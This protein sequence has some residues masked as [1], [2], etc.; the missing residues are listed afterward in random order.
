ML[1][2]IISPGT[3]ERSPWDMVLLGFLVSSVA[4]WMALLLSE[5][6]NAEPSI[7]ALAITVMALAPLIHRLIVLEEREE[8]SPHRDSLFGF[9]TRHMDVVAVYAFLFV[10]LVLSF[11]FWYAAIPI[12]DYF[13][14]QEVAIDSIQSQVATESTGHAVSAS[15]PQ[16]REQ[17][18][19]FV[20]GNNLRIMLFCFLASFLFGAGALWLI[21]WNASVLGVFI[22]FQIR[23]NIMTGILTPFALSPWAIPEIT[24]FLTAGVAGG[25]VS[26]AV[27]RH[28]F[29]SERF[30]LTIFDSALLMLFSL[31]LIFLAA[32]IEVYIPRT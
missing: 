7:I 14:A 18:F 6:I 30:W 22:G 29:K 24:G 3:A 15:S 5:Y 2:S 26:A 1:E 31:F 25:M 20:R 4:V 23:Q 32:Y 10:G 12:P 11:A 8:E 28:H 19:S 9:I 17:L 27:A 21:S 13:T 16:E